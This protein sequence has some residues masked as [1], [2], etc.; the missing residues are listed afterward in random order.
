MSGIVASATAIVQLVAVGKELVDLFNEGKLS[1]EELEQRWSANVQDLQSREARW[2][3][4][5]EDKKGQVA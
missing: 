5:Q 2:K 4:R 1:E 3:K